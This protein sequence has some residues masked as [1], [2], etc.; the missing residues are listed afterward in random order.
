MTETDFCQKINHI[1][2]YKCY[3]HL[4]ERLRDVLQ[5]KNSLK[6]FGKNTNKQKIIIKKQI[7][8][9]HFKKS[10]DIR[11]S[12]LMGTFINSKWATFTQ[13]VCCCGF[14]VSQG[15]VCL[16]NLCSL[17]TKSQ[18]S[19]WRLKDKTWN[20]FSIK[21]SR[22][23][24]SLNEPRGGGG[25]VEWRYVGCYGSLSGAHWVPDGSVLGCSWRKPFYGQLSLQNRMEETRWQGHC[26]GVRPHKL[27]EQEHGMLRFM[28]QRHH[29]HD[30]NPHAVFRLVKHQQRTF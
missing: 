5:K 30:H 8:V 27:T 16:V 29:Q 13:E 14:V 17:T 24:L 6:T 21:A 18:P 4:Y 28:G 11:G 2:H 7:Y 22:L 12:T 20:L 25:T 3:R 23:P 9:P 10:L 19:P 15:L 26:P 1:W